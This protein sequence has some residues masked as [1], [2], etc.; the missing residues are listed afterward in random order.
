MSPLITQVNLTTPSSQQNTKLNKLV[1]QHK[2]K[3]ISN[4]L[5]DSN[6][7]WKTIQ[8]LNN[9]RATTTPRNIIHNSKIYNKPQDICNI[10][11][12]YYI[13][14]IQHLRDKIPQIPV[15]PVEVLKNIYPRNTNTFTIPTPTV[16]DIRNII[17]NAESS[18]STGHDNISM[19]ILKKTID[20][21]APL[22]TH[23]TTQIILKKKFP[24]TFKIDCITPTHKKGKQIYEI[25]SYRPINNLCTIEKVIKEYI[26]G[27]LSSFLI[28]NKIINNNHHGGQKGHS[29]ITAL[30]QII[31][32][33]QINYEKK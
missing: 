11:N 30:N 2:T 19:K 9:K 14:T 17:I 6:D 18:N 26:S 13:N 3:Y 1:S 27:H 5:D 22:I 23:L 33:A 28:D 20:I 8:D 16:A 15:Q 31:K 32:T 4:K 7:R 21:M 10:A 24:Q 25:G 29:T 12:D